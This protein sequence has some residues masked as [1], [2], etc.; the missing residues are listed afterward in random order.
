MPRNHPPLDAATG[1]DV[2]YY[3]FATFDYD[4][5]S[6]QQTLHHQDMAA[7]VLNF[8]MHGGGRMTSKG[9][10]VQDRSGAGGGQSAVRKGKR[11]AAGGGQ[12]GLSVGYAVTLLGVVRVYP[13]V[14]LGGWGLGAK[15]KDDD[16][17]L[18]NDAKQLVQTGGP[19]GHVGLGIDLLLGWRRG[20]VLGVRLGW[21]RP[22]GPKSTRMPY[23]RL[24]I[25]FGRLR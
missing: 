18:P 22:L 25:G 11:V 6:A 9:A 8:P 10:W 13:L 2:R 20:A 5:T 7:D 21:Q 1:M 4:G 16:A 3:S 12:G 14:G 17:V 15:L 24:L 19:L 23:M